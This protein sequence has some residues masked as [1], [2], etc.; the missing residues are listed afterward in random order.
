MR[1]ISGILLTT[2]IILTESK[3]ATGMKTQTKAYSEKP[4]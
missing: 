4:K 2:F 3:V 1:D